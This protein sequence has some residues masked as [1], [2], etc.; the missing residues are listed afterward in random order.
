MRR[1]TERFLRYLRH[2]RNASPHTLKSY[3]E[4][5]AGLADY[6]S[7]RYEYCPRPRDVSISDLRGYVAGL[8]EAG[9]ARGTIARRLASLR[10]FFRFGHREG[11][12]RTNPAKVL[13]NPAQGPTPAA[14]PV[15][16]PRW[17]AAQRAA[18]RRSSSA[19]ATGPSWRRSIRPACG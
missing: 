15:D 17:P 5:L 12:V 1:A 16:R 7:E 14:F 9:Y 4:D 19:C 10:S 2:E 6:L 3:R 11:W 13:R 18:I 8:H